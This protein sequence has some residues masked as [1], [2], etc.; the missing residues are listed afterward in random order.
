MQKKVKTVWLLFGILLLGS[1]LIP[2]TREAQVLCIRLLLRLE[3]NTVVQGSSPGCM[4]AT[5]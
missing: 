5:A 3:G 4:I 1:V 2:A